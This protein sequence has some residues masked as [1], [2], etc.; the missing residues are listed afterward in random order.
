MSPTFT[1]RMPTHHELTATRHALHNGTA[2]ALDVSDLAS[3]ELRDML[4]ED[5]FALHG[6]IETEGLLVF[7]AHGLFAVRVEDVGALVVQAL[8]ESLE[9][10]TAVWHKV[11]AEEERAEEALER[12]R[13]DVAQAQ[14]WR[15][16]AYVAQ[17]EAHFREVMHTKRE[18][19]ER[20]REELGA[21]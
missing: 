11:R 15:E 12:A 8:T 5:E 3:A 20:A 18:A 1:H 19:L 16:R 10:A 14:A 6:V 9:H 21:Q 13:G 7:C 2:L 17:N 4:T